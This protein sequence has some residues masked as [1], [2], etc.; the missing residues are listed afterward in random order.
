M[1]YRRGGGGF[2]SWDFLSWLSGWT[3]GGCRCFRA[4]VRKQVLVFCSYGVKV[5]KQVSVRRCGDTFHPSGK[6]TLYLKVTPFDS[7]TPTHR[8]Q[9]VPIGG[10][11]VAAK[12]HSSPTPL[13]I[14]LISLSPLTVSLLMLT[15]LVCYTVSLALPLYCPII[16]ADCKLL[17]L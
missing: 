3:V 10:I 9:K 12:P 4:K 7:N 17:L 6:W 11:C 14:K 5:Q 2:R 1:Q 16:K 13:Q 8:R 15:I